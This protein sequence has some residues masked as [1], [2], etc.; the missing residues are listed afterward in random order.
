VSLTVLNPGLHT[1]LVDAGRP[2][3]RHLGVPVGGPADS[4]A[5]E[6]GNALAGNAVDAVALEIS[7]AGP[8]LRAEVALGAV[9]VGAP[10][11]AEIAGK[12]T[13]EPG[14]G[15]TLSP[16]DVLK[17]GGTPRG[18]RGYLCVPG[19]FRT[20]DVLGSRSGFGPVSLGHALACSPSRLPAVGVAW[21]VPPSP[22]TVRV[23]PGPQFD[24]FLAPQELTDGT[25]DVHTRRAGELTS[26][27]V[28]PGAVQVTNDGRPVIL[29]V[30]G[31][32]I[33]GYPKI[34]HV[35]R[36]DLDL[37]GQLRS[38]DRVRFQF[39]TPEVAEAAATERE[40]RL[41]EWRVRIEARR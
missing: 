40:R 36:A 30:D 24:W 22:V 10:F 3:A 33:G 19:G 31:Q 34:A 25:Y 32:T 35:V 4:T 27:P 15:F 23:L 13:L 12:R 21:D 38:G 8:T 20:P 1:L 26:E 29:G 11:A 9:I 41:H 16:G 14:V 18:A 28:A 39:V 6:V 5:Y 17:I 2:G 37:L 7:F